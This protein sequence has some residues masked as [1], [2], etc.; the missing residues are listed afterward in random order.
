MEFHHSLPAVKNLNVYDATYLSREHTAEYPRTRL[1][2]RF[3]IKTRQT[4]GM[5]HCKKKRIRFSKEVN[6]KKTMEE[7]SV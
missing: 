3:K 6:T 5:R 2:N 4:Q 7:D 1:R